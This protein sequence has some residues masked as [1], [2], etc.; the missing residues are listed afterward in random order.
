MD[1]QRKVDLTNDP[2]N[3]SYTLK[4]LY[5]LLMGESDP[6]Q[7][8]TDAIALVKPFVGK[9]LSNNNWRKYQLVVQQNQDNLE[10]L[11]QY[12]TNYILAS[13]GLAVIK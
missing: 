8:A 9:G 13:A 2:T 10:K 1:R 5:A 11:R 4:E 12:I 7:L 3:P 6:H